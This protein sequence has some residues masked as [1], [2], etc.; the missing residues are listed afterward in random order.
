MAKQHYGKTP[1]KEL[2]DK[3]IKVAQTRA[4]QAPSKS[5]KKAN[6]KKKLLFNLP[7][8]KAKLA[9]WCGIGAC[10]VFIV[11]ATFI[12]ASIYTSSKI[13]LYAKEYTYTDAMNEMNKLLKRYNMGYSDVNTEKMNDTDKFNYRLMEFVYETD[14]NLLAGNG[15][16]DLEHMFDGYHLITADDT[17]PVDVV[18]NDE[19]GLTV[20]VLYEMKEH[21]Y[22]LT[23]GEDRF[24]SG[25]IEN[26]DNYIYTGVLDAGD[27]ELN[28]IIA[29]GDTLMGEPEGKTFIYYY[30]GEKAYY[31][32][33]LPI[34]PGTVYVSSEGYLGSNKTGTLLQEWTYRARYALNP[35]DKYRLTEVA[36]PE[37]G[38]FDIINSYKVFLRRDLTVYSG[39]T[40]DAGQSTLPVTTVLDIT[41][42]DNRSWIQCKT[43][44]G[45]VYYIKMSGV[46][47]VDNNGKEVNVKDMMFGLTTVVE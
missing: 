16:I 34:T 3:E 7:P 2:S 23:I 5:K 25:Y 18:V 33:E 26:V 22:V 19:T 27:P 10:V 37:Q 35:D 21:G 14:G 12:L 9:M 20:P 38:C 28:R 43:S 24:E 11:V 42:T 17:E 39:V 6:D 36:S 1:K 46:S 47:T 30:D 32:G 29:C 31:C 15:S 41:G 13:D 4:K 44:G 8:E 45:N 40:D